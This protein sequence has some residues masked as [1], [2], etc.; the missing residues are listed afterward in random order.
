MTVAGKAYA[1]ECTA[2]RAR[3]EELRD[4][5]TRAVGQGASAEGVPA[6]PSSSEGALDETHTNADSLGAIEAND[7]I[8]DIIADITIR[9]Q[10]HII[11]EQAH[12]AIRS[13]KCRDPSSPDYDMSIPPATHEEAMQWPDREQ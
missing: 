8:S 4:K 9:E 6:A 12:I 10:A 5:R 7:A 11:E 13:D 1:E 2:A 3:L